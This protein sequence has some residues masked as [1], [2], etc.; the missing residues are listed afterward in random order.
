MRS[1]VPWRRGTAP[2]PRTGS[3][4]ASEWLFKHGTPRPAAGTMYSLFTEMDVKCSNCSWR[5]HGSDTVT[6]W[7]GAFGAEKECP[8]C[9]EY[10]GFTNYD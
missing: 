8:Q 7:S 5:G 1:R 10:F 3:V 4:S 6:R 2:Q 9:G